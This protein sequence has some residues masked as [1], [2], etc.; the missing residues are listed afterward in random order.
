MGG[1]A[2]EAD[3]AVPVFGRAHVMG[4][5]VD[6]AWDDGALVEVDRLRLRSLEFLD[7]ANLGLDLTHVH[8]IG[9]A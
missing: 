3:F 1:D 2:V 7:L 8:R 9:E 5:V 4:V 6:Q